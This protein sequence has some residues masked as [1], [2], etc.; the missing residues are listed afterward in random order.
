MRQLSRVE[1]VRRHILQGLRNGDQRPGAVI[2]VRDI[3]VGLG[4]SPTPVRE[5][6]E[7]LA[8]EGIVHAGRGE[9]GFSVP[10]YGA[11]ELSDLYRLLETLLQIAHRDHG[12]LKSD[13]D[14]RVSIEDGAPALAVE[15]VLSHVASR[16]TSRILSG[17]IRR[18]INILGP[19]RIEEPR[20][21]PNWRQ[22]LSDL[23]A[24]L[25]ANEQVAKS[26]RFHTKLRLQ[27]VAALIASVDEDDH[28]QIY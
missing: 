21:I 28:G 13:E 18:I 6:L 7:R 17:E 16:T 8:G 4:T 19:Y 2:N 23:R 10:R 1:G 11:R 25:I 26:I 24:S 12:P 5:A 20:I 3:A 9:R 27:Q 22:E 15:S 14:I